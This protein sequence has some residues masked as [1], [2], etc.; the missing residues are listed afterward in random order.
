[1]WD[2]LPAGGCDLPSPSQLKC[3]D[4]IYCKFFSRMLH[5]SVNS[6]TH[7]K[8]DHSESLN[9][10]QAPHTVPPS[11]KDPDGFNNDYCTASFSIRRPINTDTTVSANTFQ[12]HTVYS[13]SLS[14]D[15]F[16]C[17]TQNCQTIISLTYE[18]THWAP[19][20]QALSIPKREHIHTLF[21]TNELVSLVNELSQAYL[22]QSKPRLRE[23]QLT[24]FPQAKGAAK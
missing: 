4:N 5:L 22:D 7:L 10:L 18:D 15:I 11:C 16:Y 3:L 21:T 13:K 17:A 1:M 8:P 9:K 14:Q 24:I 12:E 23:T 20:S 19:G 2:T 6:N